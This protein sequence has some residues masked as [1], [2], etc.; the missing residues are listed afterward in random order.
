MLP[1]GPLMKEH[2]KTER[3]IALIA[4]ETE[5]MSDDDSQEPDPEFIFDA[6]LFLR[7]YVDE[8]HHGKEEDIL[9]AELK[10]RDISDE[11]RQIMDRLLEE[12][13]RGRELADALEEATER[14]EDGDEE[15]RADIIEALGSIADM[16]PDHIATEDDDF[17]IPVM[18]YFSDKEKEDMM[19][20]MW[21]FD[22]E[23]FTDLYEG[24]ITEYEDN[25]QD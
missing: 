17:F 22:H 24:C 3:M 16:Y 2:R 10:E 8:S 12:H 5:R 25:A 7:E 23:L 14:W 4:N 19:E 21:D 9:F 18:E 6:L 15:A 1:I 20:D 11:H 13:V